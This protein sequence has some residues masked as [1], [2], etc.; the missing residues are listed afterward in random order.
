MQ[1]HMSAFKYADLYRFSENMA[2]WPAY[3]V[4]NVGDPSLWN[5]GVRTGARFDRKILMYR[6]VEFR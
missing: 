1:E 4:H 6:R 5:V 3:G 2:D